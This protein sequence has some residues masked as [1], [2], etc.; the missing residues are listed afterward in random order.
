MVQTAQAGSF[1][2]SLAGEES[3]RRKPEADGTGITGRSGERRKPRSAEAGASRKTRF[4]SAG[5]RSS[6]EPQETESGA[7][8]KQPGGWTEGLR[9]GR[10]QGSEGL[11]RKPKD[12]LS[13]R[14]R[15]LVASLAGGTRLSVRADGWVTG[16]AKA[17]RMRREPKA[18]RWASWR[19]VSGEGRRLAASSGEECGK[20]R[21]P[22]AA[23]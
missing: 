2:K 21:E 6:V 3:R 7:S 15:G 16:D 10:K 13:G 5:S 1:I 18:M 20:R 9:T 14:S 12:A 23:R 11:R 22:G 17:R 4:R 8:W 19:S